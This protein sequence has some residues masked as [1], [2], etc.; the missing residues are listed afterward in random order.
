MADV[1]LSL[2]L[3]PEPSELEGVA[4]SLEAAPR[5]ATI[6]LLDSERNPLG[7]PIEVELAEPMAVEVPSG[8]AGFDW[9]RAR[10]PVSLPLEELPEGAAFVRAS[11]AGAL[12]AEMALTE[13]AAPSPKPP[14]DRRVFNPAGDWTLLLVSESFDRADRFFAAAEQL[15]QFIL[16]QAPFSDSAVGKHFR[17]EALFWP[18][19]G[20]GLF[21]TRP[22]G[23]LVSGDNKLVGKFVRKSGARGNLTVVLVNSSVRGG[24]GGTRETPAWVTI[25]SA[26]TERW[27]A[28]ALHELGHSFGLADEYDNAAQPTPEP[29]PLEPNVTAKRNGAQAPWASLRTQGLA[30]DPTVNASGQPAVPAGTVGTFE[31]ARYHKQGRYRPTANCLMRETNQPFCLVCQQAIRKVLT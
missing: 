26:A 27:E 30:H 4:P 15:H 8:D 22:N 6:E 17:T 5:S 11:A 10:A 14:T 21:N 1:H 16:A 24:A 23:R 7:S 2:W 31:G 3:E 12:L 20:S 25:T 19:G 13:A 28:V 18:S 29:N 9:T